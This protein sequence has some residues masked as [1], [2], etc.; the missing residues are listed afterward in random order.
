[1]PDDAATD[2]SRWGV[3]LQNAEAIEKQVREHTPS[4]PQCHP[5]S[6]SHCHDVL[7]CSPTL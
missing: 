3:V 4:A 7:A 5:R 6:V 2:Q 1:M